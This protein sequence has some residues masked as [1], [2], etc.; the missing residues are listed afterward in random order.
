MDLARI[1]DDE[2]A[3]RLFE[4]EK[5]NQEGLTDFKISEELGLSIEVIK[6]SQKYLENLKKSDITPEVLA[7]K[8]TELYLEFSEI[9]EEA[10]RQYE[11]YQHPILCA[12]CE[13]SGKVPHHTNENEFVVCSKCNG[14]GGNHYPR[15]ANRFLL[16]WT[17]IIEKKAK[18]FGLDNIKTDNVVQFNQFNTQTYVP[19]DMKLTGEAKELSKRLSSML[20]ESHENSVGN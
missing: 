4:I 19:D 1:T 5:L 14:A 18:L 10:K 16:T 2:R 17:L 11:L 9:A 6:R 13:G 20:K 8:R 15:D 3:K 12:Y 7:Q